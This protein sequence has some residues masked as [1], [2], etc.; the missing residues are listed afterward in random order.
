MNLDITSFS[1]I[2]QCFQIYLKVFDASDNFSRCCCWCCRPSWFK[3]VD[4]K[5]YINLAKKSERLGRIRQRKMWKVVPRWRTSSFLLE[6]IPECSCLTL[7]GASVNE[8]RLWNEV[9]IAII[10]TQR[11]RDKRIEQTLIALFSCS[12]WV[13]S[14][15][16]EEQPY[17]EVCRDPPGQ[18]HP[19]Q[20]AAASNLA[21]RGRWPP[22]TVFDGGV[23]VRRELK[24]QNYYSIMVRWL[25]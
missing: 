5:Q 25:E 21:L 1:I 2:S 24:S 16:L 7:P 12:T 18:G 15:D 10:R 4:K 23:H 6:K 22:S 8:T 3:S 19:G 17:L 9:K 14:E 13:K 11:K 20:L